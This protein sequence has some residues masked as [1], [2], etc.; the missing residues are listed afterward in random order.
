MAMTQGFVSTIR[1]KLEIKEG[2]WRLGA[3]INDGSAALDVDFSP[4]VGC[5]YFNNYYRTTP[6]SLLFFTLPP[7]LWHAGLIT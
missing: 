2:Q 3:T 6:L 5:E 7:S 1:G 4:E